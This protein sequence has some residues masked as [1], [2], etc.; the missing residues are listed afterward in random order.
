MRQEFVRAFDSVDLTDLRSA[1]A[2][3][4]D[5]DEHL[6]ALEGGNLDLIDNKRLALLH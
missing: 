2:G 3:G 4:V 1:H 5:F 6:S